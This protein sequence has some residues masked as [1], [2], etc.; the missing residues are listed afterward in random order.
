MTRDNP[1]SSSRRLVLG[2]LAATAAVGAGGYAWWRH[3]GGSGPLRIGVGQPLSGPLAPLG[4]DLVRG[5]QMAAD[6]LNAAGGVRVGGRSLPI[7]IVTADDRADPKA[8]VEAAHKLV[9]MDVTAVVAHLNSGVSIAAAPIYAAAGIPQ[10]SISTKP[11]YTRLGLPTTLRLVANDDQQSRAL[12]AFATSMPQVRRIAVVDDGTP[13]GK[14]LADSAAKVL[15]SLGH[16]PALRRT[17]D[18][19]TTDFR[20][21]VPEMVRGGID[22]MV[23]TLS[24]FQVI[25]FIDQAVSG[26][27]KDLTLI[28]GDTIKTDKLKERAGALTGGIF[29]TSSIVE[30]KEFPSGKAFVERYRQKYHAE[31]VYGAHYA[32]DAVAVVADALARD[33][34]L[35]RGRLLARLKSF[36]GNC[37]ITNSVRF[38]QDGEQHYAA[39]AA[40]KLRATQWELVVRSDRW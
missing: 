21:L 7:E 38:D 20:A 40:Y 37:P 23:T 14:G 39:V 35:D 29:A 30:P 33:N 15:E 10:L 24:D 28:G 1:N 26:G 27:L 4:E 36:D 9:A 13:Y 18:N 31:P 11:D 19:T 8:G 2:A 16:A 32:Y 12:G 34:D 22:A 5:A 3:G 25:A 17:L 6:D